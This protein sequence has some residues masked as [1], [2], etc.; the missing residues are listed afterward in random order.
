MLTELL[1][2]SRP[3]TL[4]ILTLQITAWVKAFTEVA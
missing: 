1:L 3:L 2:N 4:Q